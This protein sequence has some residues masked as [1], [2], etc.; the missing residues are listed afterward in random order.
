LCGP[1][2][3]ED[4][5]GYQ[6]R[7]FLRG[8]LLW[9]L[10][11]ATLYGLHVYFTWNVDLSVYPMIIGGIMVVL[12]FVYMTQSRDFGDVMLFIAGIVLFMIGQVMQSDIDILDRL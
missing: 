10:A 9:G 11:L 2:A 3:R 12:H 4:H 5:V 8:C 6:L 1:A 7:Y